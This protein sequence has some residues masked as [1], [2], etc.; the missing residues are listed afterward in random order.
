MGFDAYA[1]C[2]TQKRH[3]KD[4][5]NEQFCRAERAWEYRKP[6][7]FPGPVDRMVKIH[8]KEVEKRRE[9]S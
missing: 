1:A 7:S 6:D 2:A 8:L 4:M 3:T 5:K 9:E